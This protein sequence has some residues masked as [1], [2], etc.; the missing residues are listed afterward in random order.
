M[1]SQNRLMGLFSYSSYLRL[2]MAVAGGKHAIHR[3][4][5]REQSAMPL[6]P[7]YIFAHGELGLRSWT[8]GAR[9]FLNVTAAKEK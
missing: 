8:R 2:P 5:A 7:S 4:G 9:R 1:F 3:C 6:N